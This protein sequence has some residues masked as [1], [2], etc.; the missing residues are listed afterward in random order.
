MVQW[1]RICLTMQGMW[2]QSLIQGTKIPQ[3][4][5]QLNLHTTPGESVLQCPRMI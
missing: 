5:E 3:A 4:T 1:L 2:V